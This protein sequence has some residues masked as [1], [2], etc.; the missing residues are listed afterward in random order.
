IAWSERTTTALEARAVQGRQDK[1][2]T[3]RLNEEALGM[4]LDVEARPDSESEPTLGGPEPDTNES[5]T[6][7]VRAD[8][9][10]NE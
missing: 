7:D 9:G 8:G 5:D 4:L 10:D 1:T 2:V 6:S 3:R